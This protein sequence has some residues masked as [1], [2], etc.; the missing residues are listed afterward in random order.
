MGK[1]CS[2][3]HNLNTAGFGR[4]LNKEDGDGRF[5]AAVQHALNYRGPIY[6]SGYG[7]YGTP[8]LDMLEKSRNQ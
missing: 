5:R 2:P 8:A 4:F 3:Y 7:M 6:P 1:E